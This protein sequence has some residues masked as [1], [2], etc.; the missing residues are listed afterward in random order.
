MRIIKPARSSIFTSLVVFSLVIFFITLADGIMAYMAPVTI[1]KKVHDTAYVGLI[2]SISSFFGLFLDIFTA[3]KLSY[4]SLHF[5]MT[6]AFL[7]SLLFPILLLFIPNNTILLALSMIIWS[8]Y[9]EFIGYSKYNFVYKHID[10]KKHTQ[11]WA[12][13][14]TSSSIAYMLGPGL[15]VFLLTISGKLPFIFAILCV[16]ISVSIYLYLVRK[17]QRRKQGRVLPDLPKKNIIKEFKVIKILLKRLWILVLFVV[18]VSLIDVFMWTMGVL[19]MSKL[20]ESTPL[21]ELLLVVYGIPALFIGIVTEKLKLD[22]GKKKT[23]FTSAAMAGICLVFVG[24]SKNIYATLSF[25]FLTAVFYG[26]SIILI[27]ATFQDYVARAKIVGNDIVSILQFSHNLAYSFGPIL[28]GLSVKYF[29]FSNTFL[30]VGV[31]SAVV[32]IIAFIISPRKIKMPQN[33]I[34][35]KLNEQDSMENIGVI[36]IIGKVHRLVKIKEK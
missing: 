25:V 24:L 22:A 36:R 14:V 3:H 13:L 18:C 9:Y 32:S 16:F 8:I 19:Y 1:E 27:D 2:L 11:A 12:T 21:G 28:L 20:S 26:I 10:T 6:R 7:F 4:K 15:G 30:I 34:N 35:T 17:M 23:A 29:D 31:L 5:F 33:E